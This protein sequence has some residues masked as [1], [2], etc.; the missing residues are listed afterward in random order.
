MTQNIFYCLFSLYLADFILGFLQALYL[1][2]GEM[3]C[4]QATV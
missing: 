3:T 1:K 4:A 2:N